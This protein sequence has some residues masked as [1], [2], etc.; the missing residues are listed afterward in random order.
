LVESV[1]SSYS[2]W[3]SLSDEERIWKLL[4]NNLEGGLPAGLLR[5][6]T[7]FAGSFPTAQKPGKHKKEKEQ[8]KTRFFSLGLG[9]QPCALL[10][11]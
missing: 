10:T 8:K 1:S 6:F 3:T 4:A 9:S 5:P 2:Q 7:G 11:S